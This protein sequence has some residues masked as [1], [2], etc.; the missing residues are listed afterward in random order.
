M[1]QPKR[2]NHS[3]APSVKRRLKVVHFSVP[4][5]TATHLSLTTRLAIPHGLEVLR[6]ELLRHQQTFV[7]ASRVL[8]R[9]AGRGRAEGGGIPALWDSGS[10]GGVRRKKVEPVVSWASDEAGRE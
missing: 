8:R 9:F 10:H 2:R 7:T 3:D 4:L 6:C 1:P 5:D